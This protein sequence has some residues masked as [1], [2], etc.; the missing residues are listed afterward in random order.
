M[1]WQE[2]SELINYHRME[3]RHNSYYYKEVEATFVSLKKIWSDLLPIVEIYDIPNADFIKDM[4][5]FKGLIW[6]KH[7]SVIDLNLSEDELTDEMKEEIALSHKVEFDSFI[8]VI[9]DYLA[10]LATSD[11]L[12]DTL[13]SV[14]KIIL[15][16]VDRD[17]KYNYYGVIE[18]EEDAWPLI[19]TAE[20]LYWALHLL[21]SE[22]ARL[23]LSELSP[24]VFN[25]LYCA[26]QKGEN[27]F[28]EVFGE[29]DLVSIKGLRSVILASVLDTD[30]FISFF[31]KR[32]VE[33][34]ELLSIFADEMDRDENGIF[35]SLYNLLKHG[36][37]IQGINTAEIYA[38][39]GNKVVNL[40]SGGVNCENITRLEKKQLLNI[41]DSL[42]GVVPNI[43][44]DKEG[45]TFSPKIQ[46]VVTTLLDEWLIRKIHESA[47]VMSQINSTSQ[48]KGILDITSM[49][50]ELF[51]NLPR[52]DFPTRLS[53]EKLMSPSPISAQEQGEVL[54]EIY[55]LY[56]GSFDNMSCEE[57]LYLLGA[58][59]VKQPASYN[60]PYYWTGNVSTMKALIRILYIQQPR[61]LKELILHMSDKATG[62]TS[63]D[64]GRNKDSVAYQDLE[65]NIIAIIRRITG[66]T[67]KEL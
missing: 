58:A 66:K 50:S 35:S 57:F 47:E 12:K 41:K 3:E 26:Y 20:E 53:A 37:S 33:D 32:L 59:F 31:E 62:K 29:V 52:L 56:G 40:I 42:F 11:I 54:R 4:A 51:P 7:P 43:Q 5:N 64:W 16:A 39:Y 44:Q 55:N 27:N 6:S 48:N 24:K 9:K 23:I 49:K 15:E 18:G 22:K 67:L 61:I 8:K 60:P 21:G 45:L 65:E 30:E 38:F 14:I 19:L 10:N 63:H 17:L 28:S 25:R 2:N 46:N 36:Q 1:I 34:L 13:R